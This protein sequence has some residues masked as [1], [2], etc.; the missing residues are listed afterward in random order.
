[1]RRDWMRD[2][3][4]VL[5]KVMGFCI[6]L[7][8]IGIGP[9]VAF[10]QMTARGLGMGGSYTAV[11]RGVHA[12]SWN[13]AN[14][15]LPDNPGFSMTI[16]S[17][18]AGVWNNSFTL[19]MYDRYNGKHWT[20]Q[21]VEDILGHIPDD[22]FGLDLHTAVRV[23]SFSIGRMAFSFGGDVFSSVQLDKALFELGLQGNELGETY[24][25]TQSGGEGVGL[26]IARFSMGIPIPVSFADAFS[27]GG[28][29]SLL[30]GGAYVRTDEMDFTLD[31]GEYSFS[32]DGSYKATYA[33]LGEFGLGVDVGAAARFG[34]HWTVGA[35][36]TNVIGTVKWPENDS[37]LIG[38]VRGDSMTV[39]GLGEDEIDLEDS[40][41][42]VGAEMISM[43]LPQVVRFGLA[44]ESGPVLLSAA[45]SQ[46]LSAETVI[47][48][49]PRISVGTEYRGIPWL[50]IRFGVVSGGRIGFGSSFGFG[51]R[52]GGFVFDVGVLNRGFFIP[53]NSKGI[54]LAIELG[55]DITRKSF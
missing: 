24:R 4:P 30:W 47:T 18:E 3:T 7:I 11:A 46:R 52:P 19:G 6:A 31:M 5:S 13:P 14:L 21:D 37:T 44:Y 54:V 8:V 25:F 41:W 35:S 55:I 17:A 29:V 32:I 39:W 53:K 33:Y 34:E 16:L 22:G 2:E 28:T 12:V 50:P 23:M 15:G 42:T 40:T 36:M 1:M 10:S 9:A 38:F 51:I 27:I 49:K 20:P 45:V 43:Q 26:G 48:A